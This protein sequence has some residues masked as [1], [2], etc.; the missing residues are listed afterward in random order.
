MTMRDHHEP[1]EPFVE[2]LAEHI[3][4]EARR[5]NRAAQDVGWTRWLLQSPIKTA[6]AAGVLV[7]ISMGLGGIVVVAAYQAQTNEQREVLA[8]SYAQRVAIAQQRLA[9]AAEHLKTAEQRVSVG[10][11]GPETV[12]EA[13]FKV[14]E[15]EAQ[16]KST[17]L[18]LEEARATGREPLN[19]VSAPLVAG[20]DFVAERWKIEM[21]VASSAHEL[22]MTRVKTAARRFDVGL[23]GQ[24]DVDAARARA[25]ELEAAIEGFRRRIVV[26]EGFLKREIDAPMADLRL[27]E[28]EAEQRRRTLEPRLEFA[29]R[30][31]KAVKTK[32][33]SG[34]AQPVELSEAQVRVL[35]TELELV[36]TSVDLALIQRQI[37][38][39][40]SGR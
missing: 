26:R 20:R 23:A 4:L 27:L 12:L 18:Q 6:I 14:V 2:R 5:R 9:N 15:A 32:V 7:L 35:E 24:I 30:F 40:R 29:R 13:K 38:Q 37:L 1:R 19:S 21:S 31:A 11:E 28:V 16:L 10:T 34:T 25:A 17:M 8:A 36:K 3:T 22:E 33:D 39:R